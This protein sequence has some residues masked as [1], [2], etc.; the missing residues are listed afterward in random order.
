VVSNRDPTCKMAI[1]WIAKTMRRMARR[2]ALE[3]WETKVENSE[4]IPQALWP[5][6][7]SLIKG[8]GPRVPTAIRSALCITYYPNEK[9]NATANCVE[10]QFTSV[11]LCDENHER[12]VETRLQDLLAS[13][14]S[15]L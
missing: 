11:D 12:Q 4:V 3:W 5:I 13:V 14:G 6:A 9:T 2:K 10:N 8:D 15:H 1:N 7:N